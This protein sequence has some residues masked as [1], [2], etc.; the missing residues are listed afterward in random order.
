MS[1]I[2]T[3]WY[4]LTP[5]LVRCHT[6]NTHF[7][8]VDA[9]SRRNAAACRHATLC[10][11]SR[12]LRVPLTNNSLGFGFKEPVRDIEKSYVRLRR[13]FRSDTGIQGGYDQ[14]NEIRKRLKRNESV[15][16][17]DR[18]GNKLA[19][20]T[21]SEFGAIHCVCVTADSWG[22]SARTSRFSCRRTGMQRIGIR[23]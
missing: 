9:I 21:P 22:P 10:W 20:L 23:G 4:S 15:P 7:R 13:A 12:P 16:L 14:A 3:T 2:F 1:Q 5:R 18:D 11:H 17:F 8:P 19:D 6:E